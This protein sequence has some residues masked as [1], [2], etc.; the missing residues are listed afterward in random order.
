[1][2]ESNGHQTA[3]SGAATAAADD[4]ITEA[5]WELIE[6][7]VRVAGFLGAPRS[8]GEI[9]GFVFSASRPVTFEEITNGLKISA[10]SASR[11]L[12]ALRR[13]RAVKITYV[14]RD[15]RDFFVPELSLRRVVGEYLGER[16]LLWLSSSNEQLDILRGRF[17]ALPSGQQSILIDRIN[18]LLDW[19]QQIRTST[20]SALEALK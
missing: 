15:R 18:L 3:R 17:D 8:V 12:R 7:C 6:I 4:Q 16:I 1:M 2:G 11:G 9:F 20:K 5:R 13:L 19:N 14:A 10:G